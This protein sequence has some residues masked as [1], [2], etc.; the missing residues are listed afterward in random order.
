MRWIRILIVALIVLNI[1]LLWWWFTPRRPRTSLY[2]PAR[3]DVPLMGTGTRPIDSPRGAYIVMLR[4]GRS[5][6]VMKKLQD[7]LAQTPDDALLHALRGGVL[8]ST[9]RTSEA[10]TAI[11]RAL[12]ID[13]R[14]ALALAFSGDL[15]LARN[16]IPTAAA[17]YDSALIA[18]SDPIDRLLILRRKAILQL[19]QNN[20]AEAQRTF[21]EAE[22]KPQS[23]NPML[24]I[25]RLSVLGDQA[26]LADAQGDSARSVELFEK[27]RDAMTSMQKG[28][29]SPGNVARAQAQFAIQSARYSLLRGDAARAQALLEEVIQTQGE[30]NQVDTL[31]ID[32]FLLQGKKREAERIVLPSYLRLQPQVDL[33]LVYPQ[34]RPPPYVSSS[35]PKAQRGSPAPTP[36]PAPAI[37]MSKAD[38][39]AMS[40]LLAFRKEN[41]ID[42]AIAFCKNALERDPKRG[43]FL[44]NLAMLCES[45]G[46][47]TDARTYAQRALA[48]GPNQEAWH[49]L[50]LIALREGQLDNAL[51]AFEKEQDIGLG[52]DANRGGRG[53]LGKAYVLLWMQGPAAA[54]AALDRFAAERSGAADLAD[55]LLATLDLIEGQP[56][57]AVARM[58]AMATAATGKS[59]ATRTYIELA[60]LLTRVDQ[61]EEALKILQQAARD[62]LK[63]ERAYRW[64]DSAR[65]DVLCTTPKQPDVPAAGAFSQITFLASPEGLQLWKARYDK[66]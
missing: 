22:S 25:V 17:Q 56:D 47:V 62:P 21:A 4:Q 24:D 39:E 40:E 20:L 31:L 6:E 30:S 8:L 2:T 51:A 45:R 27:M 41:R 23:R 28:N 33:G 59:Y 50:G 55:G 66:R 49:A 12:S 15:A 54:R 1:A 52:L 64:I 57:S 11:E 48:V 9:C 36:R 61:P 14:C 10:A 42:D 53:A 46:A 37:P 44:G 38:Q 7:A 26:F 65:L 5:A 35:A 3:P 19:W 43:I 18:A 13:P 16:D 60:R 32:A 58:R 63:D 29:Q 34:L